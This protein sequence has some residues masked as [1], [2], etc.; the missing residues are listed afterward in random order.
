VSAGVLAW[1]AAGASVV[2]AQST[3]QFPVQFDFTSPG[4]RSMAMG[5]AFVGAAD[6]ATAAS[7]NPG[8]LAFLN[9]R[10]V[11]LEGRF[12]RFETPYLAGGRISGEVSGIGLDTVGRPMYGQD[13]DKKIGPSFGSFMIPIGSSAVLTA[14]GHELVRIE[15]SFFTPG[16]FQRAGFLGVVQNDVRELPLGG[17]RAVTITNYGATL[18]TRLST[19]RTPPESIRNRIAIGGGISVAYLHLDA[20]FSRFGVT[21]DSYSEP[22]PRL[23]SATTEQNGRSFA[24]AANLG[25]LW[26]VHTK[27]Q[28][29]AAFR[30][31]PSFSFTQRDRVV[32]P[33]EEIERRGRFKVPDIWT[34]GTSWQITDRFRTVLDYS[35]VMYSQLE[36]D[37]IRFQAL[38]SGRPEQ[39]RIEDGN[40]LRGGVEYYRQLGQNRFFIPRAGAWIDP[41]HTVRYVRTALNDAVDDRFAAALPGG[42]DLVH[43]TFGAGVSW[44]QTLEFH[45]GADLS[46]RTQQ[47]TIS[48]VKRF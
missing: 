30:L 33:L 10:E 15:N 41:D 31:G 9:R 4:A 3:A 7:T 34:V 40:E 28:V 37:F 43:I 18:G 5:G 19:P 11:S 48:V 45:G 47:V 46:S 6:D 8:G 20:N 29:G 44:S 24:V 16:I 27:W 14:Y 35:R 25:V 26:K 38:A 21:S 42:T 32:F 2:F 13:N 1:S 36:T 39:L 12:G 22:D 17:T 23:V